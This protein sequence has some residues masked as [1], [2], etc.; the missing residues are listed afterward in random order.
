MNG[1]DATG[2][3]FPL[4]KISEFVIGGMILFNLYTALAI[5]LASPIVI[6]IF[7]YN[8][9]LDQRGIVEATILVICLLYIAWRKQS[10]FRS[11]FVK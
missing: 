6:N 11:L 10:I 4:V 3:M 1:L 9:F 8:L 5:I 7:L 2:Y